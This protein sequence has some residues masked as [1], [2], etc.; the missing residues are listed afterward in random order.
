MSDMAVN[1]TG[2][3]NVDSLVTGELSI[4]ALNFSINTLKKEGSFVSKVFMGST[5]N[6]IVLL[7][8]KN[9]KKVHIF[10]PPA[11]RKNSKENFIIC[12]YLR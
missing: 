1:T 5:F 2:N 4:A 11:S 10:K 6:E 3:K 9:F 7:A 12:K 8:K